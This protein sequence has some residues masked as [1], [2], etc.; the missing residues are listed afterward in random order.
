MCGICGA[1]APTGGLDPAITTA[2]PLM[3]RDIAHRGPDG[4]GYYSDRR[5][6]LGHSRLSIIDPI[7]GAQPIANEDGSC[8]ILF[9]GEIYNHQDLRRNLIARGHR[10]R[11]NADT[12]SILH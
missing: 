10:F 7:G 6:A 1:F 3:T 4:E 9:N 2:L 5:V 8:R 12:E 11:T